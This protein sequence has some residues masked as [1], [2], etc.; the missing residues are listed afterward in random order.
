MDGPAPGRPV[1]EGIGIELRRGRHDM[2]NKTEVK[3]TD[4]ALRDEIELRA[5]FK[6]CERGCVTGGDVEDWLTAEREVL[7]ERAVDTRGAASPP[8]AIH[9]S[10][11]SDPARPGPQELRQHAG[12]QTAHRP[13]R[14]ARAMR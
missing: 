11:E 9:D 5:Y 7:A 8:S 14:G 2:N 4:D 6:Y 1:K 12:G 13:S 3:N 10:A